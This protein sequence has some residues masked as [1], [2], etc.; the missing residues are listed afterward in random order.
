MGS[1][2]AASDAITS[3][4]GVITSKIESRSWTASAQ[5]SEKKADAARDQVLNAY[6]QSLAI[7]K[8]VAE[9]DEYIPRG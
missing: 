7:A 2:A 6:Q 8:R 4:A 3:R 1:T 9:Q 5:S